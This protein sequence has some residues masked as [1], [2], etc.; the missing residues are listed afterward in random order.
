MEL[1]FDE[2]VREYEQLFFNESVPDIELFLSN[3]SN[4]YDI[5]CNKDNPLFVELLHTD[6]EMRIRKG[7]NGR[8]EYYLSRFP[9][10]A[11]EYELIGEL[12]G[13]EVKVRQHFESGLEWN[14]YKSRFPGLV[15]QIETGNSSAAPAFEL[16]HASTISHSD[17][18]ARFHKAHLHER[19]GLGNV[20]FAKDRELN[21]P[22]AIKEIKAKYAN[23][24]PHRSRFAR[25]TL[26]T[27]QLEHPGI[28]PVYGLGHRSDGTPYFAMQFI[29][30][31]TLKSAISEYHEKLGRETSRTA[32]LEFRRLL[33]RFLDVCNT[34]QYAHSQGIVHRDLKPSNI[35]IGPFGETYVVDWGLAKV[36]ENGQS[37]SKSNELASSSFS[38]FEL[39]SDETAS[40]LGSIAGSP[41]FMSPEQADG[42]AESIGVRSDIFSLGATLLNLLSNEVPPDISKIRSKGQSAYWCDLHLPRKYKRLKSICAKAMSFEQ[43]DRYENAESMAEDIENYLLDLPLVAHNDSVWEKL[44]RFSRTHRSII[45]TATVAMTIMLILAIS[46]ATWIFYERQTA[47]LAN[48]SATLERIKAEA[49]L[50]FERNAKQAAEQS[51]LE[52]DKRTRQLANSIFI[53]RRLFANFDV[54]ENQRDFDKITL[55][56]LLDELTRVSE[57]KSD[58]IIKSFL[59]SVAASR[60][61]QNREIPK[62]SEKL[63]TALI[64]LEETGIPENDKL[65]IDTLIFYG[66]AEFAARRMDNAIAIAERAVGIS[67]DMPAE[68]GNDFLYNRQLL[69]SLRLKC[70]IALDQNRNADAEK[71]FEKHGYC[72]SICWRKCLQ[73]V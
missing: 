9:Q 68:Q 19:G 4:G 53:V 72:L 58:P 64:L 34:V 29:E 30:G 2:L 57:T 16:D 31:K 63:G 14:D 41:G 37:R 45:N 36:V 55:N 60:H 22:V 66:K 17:H 48:E 10:I 73:M 11:N 20:Y 69:K 44:G 71:T 61:A 56:D 6:L 47:L 49:S 52:A 46:A 15:H 7:L 26:I 33:Q 54:H 51:R 38:L 35:M 32:D 3:S 1:S 67:R 59:Y 27:S 50:K 23:S 65:Y 39:E 21:R 25:E 70:Q 5:R 8:V 28:V 42:V 24:K 43:K 18:E 12:I 62:L 40:V 13:T